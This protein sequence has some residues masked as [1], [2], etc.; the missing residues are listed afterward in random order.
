MRSNFDIP[1]EII[2]AFE[3]DGQYFGLI[4]LERDEKQKRFRFQVDRKEYLALRRVLQL[5]PFDQTPGL[6]YR[7]FFVSYA[8]SPSSKT[9]SVIMMTVRI[10]QGQDNKQLKS[11]A[12]R[13][14]VANLMWFR[15]LKDWSH[16]S[17]LEVF[18]K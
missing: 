6:K 9:D 12:P 8:V 2:E 1:P 10:E 4:Q 14:L 3:Q 13:S 11:E 15:E 16:A 7:Y 17:Y 5:R 18:E